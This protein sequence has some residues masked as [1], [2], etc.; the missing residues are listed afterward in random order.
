[1]LQVLRV[2]F[3]GFFLFKHKTAYE[4]R[5]SEWSSDGCSSDLGVRRKDSRRLAK[6]SIAA[7]GRLAPRITAWTSS[8]MAS[9]AWADRSNAGNGARATLR[10]RFSRSEDRRVGEG[11]VSKCRY[12]WSP[13]TSKQKEKKR[14]NE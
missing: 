1:M 2:C 5:I 13:Y 8:L 4:M 14:Y 12:R 6:V 9:E 11:C 3:V 7:W 10:T